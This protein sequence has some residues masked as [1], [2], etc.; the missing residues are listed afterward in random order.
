MV[1]GNYGT[2]MATNDNGRHWATL[3]RVTSGDISALT[4]PSR[5]RCYG[6]GFFGAVIT[7]INGGASWQSRPVNRKY[8]FSSLACYGPQRCIALATYVQPIC[9]ECQP[10]HYILT[11]SDGAHHWTV[12][13]ASYSLGVVTCPALKTCLAVDYTN[14]IRKTGDGGKSWKHSVLPGKN[15]SAS[16]IACPSPTVCYVS[17]YGGIFKTT[18][19]AKT[20]ETI[21]PKASTRPNFGWLACGN[22]MTCVTLGGDGLYETK[23]GGIVWSRQSPSGFDALAGLGCAGSGTCFGVGRGGRILSADPGQPWKDYTT[24][25]RDFNRAID[26]HD[27]TACT[28]LTSVGV[29]TT[30]NG[31]TTWH[32][33]G[34]GKG[35][36]AYP[37]AFSCPTTSVCYVVNHINSKGMILKTQNRGATWTSQRNPATGT[38]VSLT[39]IS[40]ASAGTCFVTATGCLART[41]CRGAADT[42]IMNTTNG[43]V[44]WN[45]A[46]R[47]HDTSNVQPETITCP[48]VKICYAAGI[49]G[50]IAKTGDAGKTWKVQKNPYFGGNAT[51]K[52]IRCVGANM[53]VVVGIAC[54]HGASGCSPGQFVDTILV[55][56]DGGN[57]WRDH[58]QKIPANH[59]QLTA[60]LD[61]VA[62]SDTKHCFAVDAD[63]FVFATANGGNSWALQLSPTDNWLTGISCPDSTRCYAVGSGGT[64]LGRDVG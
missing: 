41:Y 61:S 30:S 15:V 7:T 43:G 44:T 16:D 9:T 22:P 42:V 48:T 54:A 37:L 34:F 64:V 28:V 25:P 11:T 8:G 55:T 2:V 12:K 39:G 18:N 21:T 40:C 58:S 20:W 6:V 24:A 51:L 23:N 59:F 13:T 49:P 1:A 31:G 57:H 14:V 29:M 45:I 26:C 53:C 36:T 52:S 56:H 50:W 46:Y 35:I 27:R 60:I 5:A 38:H 32:S 47:R 10:V 19:R 3:S 4:C 33:H 62:C 17:A 63:G